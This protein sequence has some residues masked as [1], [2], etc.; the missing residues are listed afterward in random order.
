[1]QATIVTNETRTV[2]A[3]VDGDH[4]LIDT[5][6]LPDATG[7]EL[8]PEGL[9]RENVCVP[10]RDRASLFVG[11]Q[12]DV[13]AVAGAL[14]R[15]VV[16]DPGAAIA[17]FALPA[18]GRH[19]ALREHHAPAFTLADLDGVDHPLAEWRGTKKLLVAFASW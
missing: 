19:E 4:L 13:A 12:L 6:A 15:L 10:V 7:W 11:D 9:C 8:K 1:M 3:N 18:E 14:G 16:V 17:A 2:D 5:A